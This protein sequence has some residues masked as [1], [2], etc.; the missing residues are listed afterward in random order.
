MSFS[1]EVVLSAETKR[2]IRA[3][4]NERGRLSENDLR[5][6]LDE[7]EH[8]DEDAMY[9]AY[10]STVGVELVEVPS[11]EM[12]RIREGIAKADQVE[13]EIAAERVQE[14]RELAEREQRETEEVEVLYPLYLSTL[15][16]SS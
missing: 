9:R 6:V 16:L 5:A 8:V 2:R 12:A 11:E 13:R 1:F 4:Q 3:R 10:C 14:A 7:A 15:G